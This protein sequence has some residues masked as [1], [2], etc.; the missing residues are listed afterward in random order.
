MPDVVDEVASAES[1]ERDYLWNRRQ[2][3]LVKA[4]ANRRYQLE[5]QRIMEWREGAVKVASLV[6]GSA[7]IAKV[8]DQGVIYGAVAVIFI[9]TAA[10]LVFGWGGKARD[11]GKR[12]GEWIEFEASIVVT[13]ERDFTEQQLNEW[14]ARSNRL[15][16]GEPAQNRYLLEW[17]YLQACN[18]LGRTPT[19]A[20]SRL[21]KLGMIWP[22]ALR[23]LP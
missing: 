21:S 20:A 4:L 11:A 5:R 7:A 8:A 17:C 10:S 15:E 9:G 19:Q 16:M 14:Q 2:D 3:L 23:F 13:G 1:R 18:D 22:H 6:A 12:A